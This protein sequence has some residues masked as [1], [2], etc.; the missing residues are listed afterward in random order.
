M[1]PDRPTEPKLKMSQ[2]AG[3][4][5]KGGCELFS[6]T[7]TATGSGW[8]SGGLGSHLTPC[9][10]ALVISDSVPRDLS[11]LGMVKDGWHKGVGWF[12]HLVHRLGPVAAAP[13][14]QELPLGRICPAGVST[15]VT[16]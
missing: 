8:P 11:G 7:W 2:Q 14:V 15:E 16:P 9:S 12:V 3:A 1:L 10:L 6:A 13:L 5:C 4:H